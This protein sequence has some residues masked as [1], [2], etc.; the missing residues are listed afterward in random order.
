MILLDGGTLTLEQLAAIADGRAT[1]ALAGGAVAAVRRGARGGRSARG[2]RRARVRHQH[3]LR[4]ARRGARFRSESL[5]ALQVNLLRSH[6]A[7]VGDAAARPRGAR[8]DGAARERA[9]EGLSPAS[10]ARRSTAH[11]A[12]QRARASGRAEPRIG[13]RE[14]RSRP[15]RAPGA[16][17]DRR[18]VRDLRRRSGG[19]RAAPPRSA[20]AG[21]APST[22][23]PRKGSRSSTARRRRRRSLALALARRRTAGARRRRRR[24][25]HH[26][27]PARVDPC[28]SKR[29]STL[30]RPHP[31][32]RASAA[33][34][35]AL[36]AAQRDQRLARQLRP[37]AGRLFDAL[38]PAGARRGARR[39]RVRAARS[40]R[41][42]RTPPP[43]TRWCSP[44]RA[45][46][47]RA[48][49]FTARP[50]RSPPTCSCSASSQLATI[51]ERRTDRLVN[52][53]LSGL[54]PFLTRDGGLAFGADD[55]AGD[56]R[57]ARLRAEDARASGQRRHDPDVG[58]QEDH[59]SMSMARRA[60]G[61]SARSTWRRASSPIELLCACQAIDLLAP[62]ATSPRA[63]ARARARARAR[64][65][66]RRRIARRRADSQRIAASIAA[67]D[68]ANARAPEMSSKDFLEIHLTTPARVS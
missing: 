4:I 64:A 49:T 47:S 3:R 56:R 48:A 40:S 42:R 34:L 37:R 39:V 65:D 12:A 66:A 62:L 22:W 19:R 13:R 58:Q 51:S 20:R 55:G 36:L 18:R 30:P 60:E 9:G 57:G 29:A 54:P 2:G 68:V 15:A 10:A 32:Q 46:S 21:L 53:A 45:T 7:G 67:G 44:R 6:A 52:P 16:R 25:A 63:G 38:R 43:T 8:D 24:G 17:A 5:G 61:A 33:N 50:W 31:G 27:R 26:R 59:V 41:S 28:R 14:R 23:R 35:F 1:V 11:R